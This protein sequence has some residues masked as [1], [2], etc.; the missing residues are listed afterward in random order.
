MP[1]K[2]RNFW[3]EAEVDGRKSKLSS[4]PAKDDGGMFITLFI[5]EK[6]E[7]SEKKVVIKCSSVEEKNIVE[8]T[9]D[10]EVVYKL[11]VDR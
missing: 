1:Q 3:L 7:I 5:R 9:C 11:C 8:V 4:G 10:G 2:V 6:E